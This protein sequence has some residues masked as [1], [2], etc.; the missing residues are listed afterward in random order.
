MGSVPELLKLGR[1]L[2]CSKN[3]TAQE[4]LDT[5]CEYCMSCLA[6]NGTAIVE[7]PGLRQGVCIRGVDSDENG[8]VFVPSVKEGEQAAHSL[9]NA[10]QDEFNSLTGRIRE[11]GFQTVLNSAWDRTAAD[12]A[13]FNVWSNEMKGSALAGFQLAVRAGPICEEPVRNVLVVLEGVE[14]AV[15]QYNE[16]G[17]EV[18]PSWRPSKPVSGGMV[19]SALRTGVR[20]AL[21]TRPARLM[22]G[23]LRLTL[24]SSLSGLGALY[25]VLSKRRGKVVED[26]MV[27]GTDL[28]LIEALLPQAEAFGLAP[29]LF[30]KTSGEVTA[31]EMI[32]SHW[33]RLDVDPFW[34]PTSLEEREDFGELLIA[35]DTSTGID[36]T[37]LNYIRKVR[38]RKGLTVDSSRTVVAAEKQRTLKR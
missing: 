30:G 33:E 23:I 34:I 15:Q 13:A 36:N 27:E 25:S 9:K 14:I 10:G 26:S 4:V 5:L 7:S 8:E 18:G 11:I 12:E 29:E 38:Q 24:H 6:A 35:G 22:E 2:K 31:P 28:L 37:A 17:E 16:D 3:A 1:A 19:V 20:C 21:L 32:F